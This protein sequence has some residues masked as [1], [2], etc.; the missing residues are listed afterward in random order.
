MGGTPG[1]KINVVWDTGSSNLWVPNTQPWLATTGHN[2]YDHGKSSTYKAN[3]TEFYIGYGSGPVSGFYSSDTISFAGMKLGDFAFA[4]IN[5]TSGLGTAYRKFDGVLG[6]GFDSIS[7]GHVPTVMNALV[8]SKQLDEPVFGFFLGNNAVGELEFGGVDPRHYSGDFTYVP[9]SSATYWEVLLYAIKL[10]G[11]T[12][13][14]G[15]TAI[16]DSGTSLLAGPR[17]EINAIAR[18]LGATWLMGKAWAVD[19]SKDVPDMTFTLDGD[20]DFVLNREDLTLEQSGNQ[21]VLGM[22]G[23]DFPFPNRPHWILGDVFMRKYYVKF[24]WGNKRVGF[25]AA[26]AASSTVIV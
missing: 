2:I 15:Y 11:N 26:A 14:S 6:L 5:D 18:K 19:C 13:S 8:A 20:K 22:Q 21:C 17:M 12:V 4:E 9:L 3:G 10:G 7:V 24:D 25:A 16:V 23:L 1:Q